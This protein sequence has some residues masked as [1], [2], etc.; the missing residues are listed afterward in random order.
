M[1]QIP[2]HLAPPLLPAKLPLLRPKQGRVIAGVARGISM[3]LGV[4]VALVRIVFVLLACWFGV[5]AL[6]YVALWIAI[7]EGNPVAEAARL[8]GTHS[9][10]NAPLARGNASVGESE[11]PLFV[12]QT[13]DSAQDAW[14][15][16]TGLEQSTDSPSAKDSVRRTLA[17]ASKPAIFAGIG[18]VLI[19]LPS[20]L[21][22]VMRFSGS[23]ML[24]IVPCLAGMGLPWLNTRARNGQAWLT[25]VGEGLIFTAFLVFVAQT[26]AR[27]GA[28]P[29]GSAIAC[30]FALLVAAICALIPLLMTL[31]RN[32]WQER[33]LKEREEERADMTAHLHDG[34]LQTLALIQLHA[35][36]EQ[37]VFTLARSQERELRSWLYQER[38]TSDRSVSAG[39]QEIAAQV[40][41]THGKP[42]EVVTVGDARR[43]RRPMRCSMRRG[44]RWSTPSRTAENR[45]P[46]IARRIGIRWRCLC[47]TTA[48][49]STS[50]TFRPNGSAYASRSS[51]A[52]AGAAAR[53]RLC[54]DPTGALKCACIC[55]LRRVSTPRA[56][57]TPPP[58]VPPNRA[59]P[60]D[61]P[62]PPNPPNPPN[63][64][65]KRQ[66]PP[67][68]CPKLRKLEPASAGLPHLCVKRDRFGT[69]RRCPTLRKWSRP[70]TQAEPPIT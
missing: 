26:V 31:I 36:D 58:T 59:I 68:R 67:R 11:S 2:E 39:L 35:D 56:R 25:L 47:E 40:E 53:W 22:A 10:R 30:G 8:R 69:P 34:V 23:Q 55:R 17:N 19:A 61:L 65:K 64:R 28:V 60:Y 29:F 24:P 20:G 46:C 70:I 54:R 52:C 49:G 14:Y 15:A 6:A 16:Y 62:N 44:R 3:H 33:A 48:T 63:L 13:L 18:V 27:N 51:G 41:D 1:S 4:S 50:T 38:T 9:S 12:S 45:S 32:I 66:K 57:R 37:Q 7:P 43:V 21:N 5:G 42:I